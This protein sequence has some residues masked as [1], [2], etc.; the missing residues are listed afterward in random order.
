MIQFCVLA[1]KHIESNGKLSTVAQRIIVEIRKGKSF[2]T[3]I[4]LLKAVLS[5]V[6]LAVTVL[7][8]QFKRQE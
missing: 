6:L 2:I 5:G 4:E 8:V 3:W 1:E 7:W